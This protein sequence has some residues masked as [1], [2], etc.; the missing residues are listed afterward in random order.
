ME[1]LRRHVL[2]C[3]AIPAALMCLAVALAMAKGGLRSHAAARTRHEQAS[4]AS[5]RNMSRP[6][7]RTRMRLAE[8]YGKLPLHFEANQG[9]TDARVKFLSRGAGY[10]LFLTSTEAVF[11]LQRESS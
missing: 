1:T 11:K 5:S 9:Q 3:Y 7:Q 6:D 2:P 8:N 10:S 4:H